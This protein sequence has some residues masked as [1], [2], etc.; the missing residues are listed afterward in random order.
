MKGYNKKNITILI[1]LLIIF[2]PSIVTEFDPK[3]LLFI[4]VFF[5]IIEYFLKE[6]NPFPSP[7]W[8]KLA[9]YLGLG[10]MLVLRFYFGMKHID[11]DVGKY[12]AML[13]LMEGLDLFI[14]H[15]DG[16]N[17]VKESSISFLPS[18]LLNSILF[19]FFICLMALVVVKLSHI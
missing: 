13:A 10:L 19:I 17:V 4:F 6:S 9:C 15:K 5:V 1:Y 7:R 3:I 16:E 2:I 18:E 12:T 8:I 14:K 11:E